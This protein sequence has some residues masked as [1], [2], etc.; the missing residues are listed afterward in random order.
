M[1]LC[2]QQTCWHARLSI[3]WVIIWSPPSI[4]PKFIGC[5]YLV[6]WD[7][8]GDASNWLYIAQFHYISS[9]TLFVGKSLERTKLLP[10]WK[11]CHPMCV[12]VSQTYV[13]SLQWLWV[14][15]DWKYYFDPSNCCSMLWPSSQN[16]PSHHSFPSDHSD[17]HLTKDPCY[18]TKFNWAKVRVRVVYSCLYKVG[19]QVRIIHSDT[20]SCSSEVAHRSSFIINGSSSTIVDKFILPRDIKECKDWVGPLLEGCTAAVLSIVIHS[21]ESWK[22]DQLS[23]ILHLTKW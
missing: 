19:L 20:T 5:N 21:S 17:H 13:C 12:K 6:E 16:Y 10:L 23:I 22:K 8:D 7:Q 1:I 3:D 15:K 9:N 4:S 14:Q 11:S 2:S 18:Q